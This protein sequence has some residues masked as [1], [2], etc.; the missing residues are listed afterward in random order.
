LS[1]PVDTIQAKGEKA[2]VKNHR[3]GQ[4]TIRPKCGFRFNL[5]VKGK[6]RVQRKELEANLTCERRNE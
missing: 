1:S 3:A 6:K 2:S 4:G 5:N